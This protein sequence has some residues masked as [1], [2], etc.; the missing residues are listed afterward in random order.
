MRVHKPFAQ[1][2]EINTVWSVVMRATAAMCIRRA[3]RADLLQSIWRVLP[4]P[5]L[6]AECCRVAIRLRASPMPF[7]GVSALSCTARTLHWK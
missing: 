3:A 2:A 7:D 6:R 5:M 4:F 1:I